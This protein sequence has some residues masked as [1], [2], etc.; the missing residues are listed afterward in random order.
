MIR[1]WQPSLTT[2]TGESP[3]MVRFACRV[4]LGGY[5]VVAV[6]RKNSNRLKLKTWGIYWVHPQRLYRVH[7]PAAVIMTLLL[8]SQKVTLALYSTRV[9]YVK[10]LLRETNIKLP[11]VSNTSLQHSRLH[12]EDGAKKPSAKNMKY[13]ERH[14]ARIPVNRKKKYHIASKFCRIKFLQFSRI[15]PCPR[16]F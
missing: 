8:I 5:A 7:R 2:I 1:Q 16:K 9:L 14:K 10:N 12:S 3:E 15:C 13:Y 11:G 4:M 6:D